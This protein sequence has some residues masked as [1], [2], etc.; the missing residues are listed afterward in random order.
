MMFQGQEFLEA[1]LFDSGFPVDWS[2][3]NRH[4]GILELYRDLIHLRRNL[5]GG[6]RGLQGEGLQ[7]HHM[8]YTDKLIGYHRWQA[9]GPLDDTVVLLNFSN[10]A[11]G[12]YTIGVPRPGLWRVRLNSDWSGYDQSFGNQMSLDAVA[13]EGT[14]DGMPWSIGIG[15]GTYAALILS[16][17]D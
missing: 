8:N 11:F 16:Q 10:R 4:A 15:I 2:N 9:G 1:H 17:D 6:T 13:D 14:Y 12:S 3:A 5:S 7:T